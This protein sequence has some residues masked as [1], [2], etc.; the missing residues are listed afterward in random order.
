MTT[1]RT[2]TTQAGRVTGAGNF[3]NQPVHAQHLA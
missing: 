1:L 3:G 2:T